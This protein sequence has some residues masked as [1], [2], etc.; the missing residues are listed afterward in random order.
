MIIKDSKQL[1]RRV[2]RLL[3][4]AAFSLALVLP[5]FASPILDVDPAPHPSKKFQAHEKT[6][7]VRGHLNEA[8]RQMQMHY[9]HAGADLGHGGKDLVSE[10]ARGKPL[11]ATVD[12]GRG[13]GGFGK[14]VG[15]GTGKAT[16]CIFEGAANAASVLY[17]HF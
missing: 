9:G 5:A 6:Y 2:T 4:A 16:V 8:G 11:H 3:I 1:M 15:V 13:V 10:T 17:R 7:T 14:N 12:F